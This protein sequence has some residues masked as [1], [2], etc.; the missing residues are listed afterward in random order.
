MQISRVIKGIKHRSPKVQKG[1]LGRTN[2]TH[3]IGYSRE[4]YSGLYCVNRSI[5]WF[6]SCQTKGVG[7]GERCINAM[8]LQ[9]S[10]MSAL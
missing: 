1:S 10:E 5:Q 2:V 9:G 8:G 7:E 4:H 3:Q 6:E